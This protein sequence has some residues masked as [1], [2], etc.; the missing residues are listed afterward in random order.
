MPKTII[1]VESPLKGVNR[2]AGRED[3]PPISVYDS[4]NVLPFDRSGRLR[5][6][7]RTGDA[8]LF[9][10]ISSVNVFGLYQ[11]TLGQTESSG[12]GGTFAIDGSVADAGPVAWGSSTGVFELNTGLATILYAREVVTGTT[13]QPSY[14]VY[15]DDN[16]GVIEFLDLSTPMPNGYMTYGNNQSFTTDNGAALVGLNYITAAPLSTGSDFSRWMMFVRKQTHAATGNGWSSA[17]VQSVFAVW[18]Y[19]EDGD[20]C[21]AVMIWN[22][23]EIGVVHGQPLVPFYAAIGREVTDGSNIRIEL[24]TTINTSF[25]PG[26]VKLADGSSPTNPIFVTPI[27]TSGKCDACNLFLWVDPS[28]AWQIDIQ[29][30]D[31]VNND[32]QFMPS[33]ATGTVTNFTTA[34]PDFGNLRSAYAANGSNRSIHGDAALLTD[35][36]AVPF[37]WIAA[38]FTVTPSG[39]SRETRLLATSAGDIYVGTTSGLTDIGHFLTNSK[40]SETDFNGHV[41]Y[42]DGTNTIDVDVR[43]S[44]AAALVA[45]TGTV[46]VGCRIAR[47]WRG[48]L[49]LAGADSDPQN[50][51]FS[52]AGDPT[53]WDFANPAPG[54]AFAGNAS[55]AGRVGDVIL[56]MIP[57]SNDV[58]LIMGDHSIW[59]VRGDPTDGGSIDIVSGAVGIL[60]RD[61]WCLGPDGSVYFMGTGGLYQ[62]PPG[63]QVTLQPL[64][65]TQYPQFFQTLDRSQSYFQMAYNRDKFGFYAFVTS[66]ATGASTHF[67]YDSRT[68]SMW[69]LQYPDAHGPMSSLVYDG[70][71][72]NDRSLLLGGRDGTIRQISDHNRT[73]DSTNIESYIVL[74]PFNP[75]DG[76]A[77]VLT[78]STFDFGELAPADQA[79]PDRWGVTVSLQSGVDAYEVTEGTPRSTATIDCP[80]ERRQKTMRQRLRGGWFTVKLANS[81]DNNYWAFE[82]AIFEFEPAG[83]LRERR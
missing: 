62:I 13:Y 81:A 61:A 20:T 79:N 63:Y 19:S 26:D 38:T 49:V 3:Q 42:V 72:P 5:I 68:Q 12:G 15:L 54:A 64:S 67:W 31:Y 33:V 74:G 71:G 73:D 21:A 47:S 40:P 65:M 77:A 27:T 9:D 6:G 32:A 57:F 4:L 58:M 14:D 45:S 7:Q 76:G 46:P 55:T 34:Y 48:R 53:N 37:E 50:F 28:G 10:P 30:I 59:A 11:V 24:P 56:D 22:T 1:K 44:A 8:P 82:T 16:N 70:D 43:N 35:G 75:V 17:F 51:F 2:A 25:G 83:R 80:I 78:A 52:E 29:V 39:L 60:G 69:P 23:N 36:V 66:I 41:Y 18:G